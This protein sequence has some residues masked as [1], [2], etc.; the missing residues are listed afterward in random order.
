[1]RSRRRQKLENSKFKND[2]ARTATYI[3][4]STVRTILV[5]NVLYLAYVSTYVRTYVRRG[6]RSHSFV[7]F[8]RTL[9][10]SKSVFSQKTEKMPSAYY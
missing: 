10:T 8:V 3:R 4:G 1:M 7:H 6:Y 5:C 2:I 9:F